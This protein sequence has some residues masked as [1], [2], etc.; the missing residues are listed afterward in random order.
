M[1]FEAN[2]HHVHTLIYM[3]GHYLTEADTI[4]GQVGQWHYKKLYYSWW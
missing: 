3:Y 1:D 4:P 2:E